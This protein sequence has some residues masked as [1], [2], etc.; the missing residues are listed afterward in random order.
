MVKDEFELRLDEKAKI[1]T[2]CQAQKGLNSCFN[3]ELI[4]ECEIRKNYVDAAYNS[5][6]KGDS[7][8]F[9]F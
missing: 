1:L 9:E 7:G 4:F 6:S 3:C 5:M 2:D 8:G